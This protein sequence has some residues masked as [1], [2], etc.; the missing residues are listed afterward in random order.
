MA[1]RTTTNRS[2]TEARLSAIEQDLKHL[3]EQLDRLATGLQ[4]SKQPITAF[5]GWAAVVLSLVFAFGAPLWQT[6]HRFQ[7]L[8]DDIREREMARV[9]ENQKLIGQMLQQFKT[10]DAT[11]E[12][13]IA[14]RKAIDD[15]HQTAQERNFDAILKV[16]RSLGNGL[17]ERIREITEPLKER[18]LA[19]E[20]QLFADGPNYRDMD[21]R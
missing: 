6:D 19:V 5:A 11:I 7:Q 14:N 2:N 1:S 20:R 12:S 8:I 13:S 9:S 10:L 17:G 15:K 18:L 3:F 16:E 4:H 21:R